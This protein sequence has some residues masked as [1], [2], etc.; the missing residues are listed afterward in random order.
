MNNSVCGGVL[1]LRLA[2]KSWFE[3][4][5]T[6][7]LCFVC[8]KYSRRITIGGVRG[9]AL[10]ENSSTFEPMPE[11]KVMNRPPNYILCTS[12]PGGDDNKQLE[13]K[14]CFHGPRSE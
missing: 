3:R 2:P 6:V 9:D 8:V 13:V 4:S 10:H 1:C 7:F 14:S 12:S 5:Y 11:K